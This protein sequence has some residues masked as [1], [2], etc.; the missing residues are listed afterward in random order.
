MARSR[1]TS[2]P[3]T[4]R[5]TRS[6]RCST[7]RAPRRAHR[8]CSSKRTRCR[9]NNVRHRVSVRPGPTRSRLALLRRPLRRAHPARP[10]RAQWARQ[11]AWYP[12]GSPEVP[13]QGSGLK[14]GSAQARAAAFPRCSRR[15]VVAGGAP[16]RLPSPGAAA[17]EIR[18]HRVA[19]P[20]G[21]WGTALARW[22]G[23]PALAPY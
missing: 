18:S 17:A 20:A 9:R 14:P 10:R 12:E 11:V 23:V 2:R 21:V 4:W 13:R 7:R 6:P 15:P 5:R 1:K 3:Q 22:S 8:S 16:S 19:V